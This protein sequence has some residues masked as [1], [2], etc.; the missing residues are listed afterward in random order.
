MI[1]VTK[2]PASGKTPPNPIEHCSNLN[3]NVIK[4]YNKFNLDPITV[5]L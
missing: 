1:T 3:E 4:L 5:M 2:R